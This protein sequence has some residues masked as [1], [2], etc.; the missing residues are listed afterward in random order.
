MSRV[1]IHTGI[2]SAELGSDTDGDKPVQEQRKQ[3]AAVRNAT[4]E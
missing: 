1:N 4:T 3:F 2:Y